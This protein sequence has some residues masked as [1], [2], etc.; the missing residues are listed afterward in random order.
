MNPN[1]IFGVIIDEEWHP[2]VEKIADINGVR[3][4]WKMVTACNLGVY[5]KAEGFNLNIRWH[6]VNN[7]QG[8][9]MKICKRCSE[10]PKPKII[11]G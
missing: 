7:Q 3:G 5:E 10:G 4:T 6:A 2:V 8:K 1:D 11:L 9:H